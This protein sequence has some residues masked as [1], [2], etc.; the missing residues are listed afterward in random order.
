MCW[1]G[2][3]GQGIRQELLY[4][5]KKKIQQPCAERSM[6]LH[7]TPFLSDTTCFPRGPGG[8]VVKLKPLP[9]GTGV[10]PDSWN[11]IVVRV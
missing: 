8:K 11:P 1:S 10:L 5:W 7:A 9:Q 2:S 6:C 4:L 3:L